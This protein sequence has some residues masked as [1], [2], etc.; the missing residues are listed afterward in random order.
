MP[1]IQAYT[2]ISDSLQ[3][4]LLELPLN[5]LALIISGG[6]PVEVQECTEVELGR[7]KELNLADV[8]LDSSLVSINV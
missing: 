2:S 7:L 3:N 6:L 5:L 1:H 4:L 8:H